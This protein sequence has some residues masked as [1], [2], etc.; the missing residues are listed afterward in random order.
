MS[1]FEHKPSREEDEYFARE[2]FE[3]VRKLAFKQ[4]QALAAHERET[5]KKLHHMK[6]PNCGMD[7]HSVKLGKVHV[8]NCFHCKGMFLNA[9]VL[10]QLV[11]EELHAKRAVIQDVLTLFKKE[12]GP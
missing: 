7:L 9:G 4:H 3:K 6:C 8:D 1:E 5:L 12:L 2:D 11:G 10:E